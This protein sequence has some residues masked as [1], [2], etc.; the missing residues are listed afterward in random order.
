MALT[1]AEVRRRD[2]VGRTGHKITKTEAEYGK[3]REPEKHRCGICTMFLRPDA[4]SLVEGEIK[5][6][7]GCKYF[8]HR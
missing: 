5:P 6:A 7:Y 8:E 1:L 2:R 4:C 3:S